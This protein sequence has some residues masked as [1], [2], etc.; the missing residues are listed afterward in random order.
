MADVLE[1]G[2]IYFFYRPRVE[3]PEEHERHEAR[4]EPGAEGLED[5]HRFYMVLSP[6]G[7]TRYRLFLVG[8][9]K[10]PEIQNGG[11]KYWAFV[12]KVGRAA[13]DVEDELD[14]FTYPTKTRGER[15]LP[16]ARP[17]GEGVYAIARHD[18][19]THLAYALELPEKPGE[20]QR[21]LNIEDEGSYVLSIKNPA[22]PSPPGARLPR[23]QQAKYPKRLKEKFRD[24]RFIGAD[25]PDFLDYEGT[26]CLLIGA[27]EDVSE[28]L[29]IELEPQ[30]ETIEKAEIFNDLRVEKSQHPLEPLFEGKWR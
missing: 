26:A 20:V 24:R 27:E 16:P 29:G 1:Q 9:K 5:I 22:K 7:K 2:N 15:Y 23:G 14:A 17:A 25:P 13:T 19:H 3:S 30:K 21:E 18:D 6:H 10:L 28:E 12:E 8:Q 4:G 11:Q